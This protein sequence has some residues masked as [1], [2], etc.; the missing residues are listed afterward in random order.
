M[1]HQAA[2]CYLPICVTGRA[3]GLGHIRAGDTK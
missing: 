3:T 2:D 1:V